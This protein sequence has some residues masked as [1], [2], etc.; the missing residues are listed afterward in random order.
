MKRVGGYLDPVLFQSSTY[1]Y[2]NRSIR[3]PLDK[4]LIRCELIFAPVPRK[5][6]YGIFYYIVR[7]FQLKT[8]NSSLIQKFLFEGYLLNSEN[9]SYSGWFLLLPPLLTSLSLSWI[10]FYSAAPILIMNC[11]MLPLICGTDSQ[12]NYIAGSFFLPSWL[13]FSAAKHLGLMSHMATR[14]S[15]NHCTMLC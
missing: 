1:K 9:P 10:Q 12:R 14:A 11:Q 2:K 4:S 13:R 3:S 5:V 8:E 6:L 7:H 15:I